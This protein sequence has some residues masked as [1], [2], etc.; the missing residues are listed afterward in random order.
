MNK[1]TSGRRQQHGS[2]AIR[3]ALQAAK[4]I[5]QAVTATSFLGANPPM[6]KWWTGMVRV[7]VSLKHRWGCRLNCTRVWAPQE[8]TAAT[9]C[10]KNMW[11]SFQIKKLDME[12]TRQTKTLGIPF[13]LHVL[14][15][16]Y[17]RVFGQ[18]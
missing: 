5:H 7:R 2:A 8:M 1:Q 17:L 13:T 14:G 11:N 15:P 10:H 16:S 18:F 9:S 6:F 4:S 12:Q 3:R